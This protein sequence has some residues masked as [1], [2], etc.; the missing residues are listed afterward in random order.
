MAQQ[1]S[2][3]ANINDRQHTRR[4]DA[5][6]TSIAEIS[7]RLRKLLALM[8]DASPSQRTSDRNASDN[9]DTLTLRL[10]EISR[11]IVTDFRDRRLKH[12]QL[13]TVI[14][15]LIDQQLIANENHRTQ[16]KSNI[17]LANLISELQKK[18]H[19]LD[20]GIQND[21]TLKAVIQLQQMSRQACETN[22]AR[23]SHQILALET[24]LNEIL[25]RLDT[26]ALNKG[27]SS[28]TAETHRQDRFDNS[29]QNDPNTTDLTTK[30]WQNALAEL[31]NVAPATRRI[32][33]SIRQPLNINA[34][35]RLIHQARAQNQKLG[36]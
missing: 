20:R 25:R 14:E 33:P 15:R 8:R 28:S 6:S 16:T 29:R 11:A 2:S 36:Y 35:E 17:Q 9:L 18:F 7:D 19:T 30:N 13:L 21:K 23:H 3:L 26:F 4:A 1:F 31:F 32:E 27:P 22:T 34:A 10:D 5:N 12:Q 24:K